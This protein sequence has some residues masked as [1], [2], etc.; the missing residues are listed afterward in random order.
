MRWSLKIQEFNLQIKHIHG[1]ENVGA[2]TLTRYPQSPNDNQL[3]D[4]TRIHINKLM[5]DTYSK[6]LT[7]QF[8]Q[9][10]ELQEQDQHM[11]QIMGRIIEKPDHR[12]QMYNDIL[13]YVDKVRKYRLMIPAIM[14]PGLVKE[15]HEQYEHFGATK[16]YQLLR[17]QYQLNWMYRTIKKITQSCDICQKSK[18]K[19]RLARGPLVSNIPKGPRKLVSLDLIGPL[20][21]GQLGARYILVLL[22]VFTKYVQIYP[23]KKATTDVILNRIKYQYILACG[24]FKRI[25]TDNGTQFHCKK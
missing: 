23:I 10:K 1:K 12:Y 7:Q 13:F 5:L 3:E 4:Y 19:N 6:T 24:K 8:Q 11:K 20:P 17:F 14:A 21:R 9:L 15:T 2:D 16:V 22:D 18:I 25:L